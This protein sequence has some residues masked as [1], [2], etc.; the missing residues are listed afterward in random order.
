MSDVELC[1]QPD[2]TPVD[3]VNVQAAPLLAWMAERERIFVARSSGAATPW[4]GDPIL[5]QFRFCNVRREDDAATR[6]FRESVRGPLAEDG[7]AVLAATLIFRWFN[8]PE[9]GQRL[10]EAGAFE[11][12]R[13]PRAGIEAA[14]RKAGPPWTTGAYRIG[15]PRGR[16]K[17]A[18][19]CDMVEAALPAVP[20]LAAAIQGDGTLEGAHRELERTVAY[21][22]PFSAYEVVCDLRHTCLLRAAP[23]VC[24]WGHAG[25]GARRGLNRL[26]GRPVVARLAQTQALGEMRALLARARQRRWP[27]SLEMREI[28]GALCEYDKHERA[29]AALRRGERPRLRPFRGGVVG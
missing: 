13:W 18:G 28:E 7:A 22:G 19:L 23:D 10:L 4:T 20:A 27:W 21:L 15:S 25:P 6:W 16:D 3:G 5:A 9:V 1:A 26:H 11:R 24:T 14:L 17:L 2:E 12:G 29:A 8:R